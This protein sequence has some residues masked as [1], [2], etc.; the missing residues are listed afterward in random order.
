MIFRHGPKCSAPVC[1]RSL[2]WPPSW[3]CPSSSTIARPTTTCIAIGSTARR[4]LRGVLHCFMADAPWPEWALDRGLYL[5]IAGPDHLCAHPRCV[6]VVRDVPLER[7]LIET[8]APTWR[9]PYARAPQRAGLCGARGRAP[10]A[11][12]GALPSRPWPLRTNANAAALSCR[13]IDGP[14]LSIVIVS[15]NVAPLLRACLD[16]PSSRSRPRRVSAAM[17]SSA[18]AST[19]PSLGRR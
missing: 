11:G 5:G 7:L 13:L 18:W 16:S 17:G 14:D 1:E 8:D 12:P 3:I 9:P 10:G 19:A 4:A 2:P 6:E 15:W